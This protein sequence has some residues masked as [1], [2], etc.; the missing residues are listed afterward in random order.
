VYSKKIITTALA[1]MAF[2]TFSYGDYYDQIEK[3]DL[4]R[5]KDYK[6][7]NATIKKPDTSIYMDR[8][9]NAMKGLTQ[10]IDSYEKN[11]YGGVTKK[12]ILNN[13]K[14]NPKGSGN[15]LTNLDLDLSDFTQKNRI[16]VFMSSSV[17][18][19]IWYEYGAFIHNNKL[20]NASMLIRGCVNGCKKIKPTT[21]FMRKVIEYKP[22]QIINPSILIDPLLFKRFKMEEVPCVVFA[23]GVTITNDYEGSE[24]NEGQVKNNTYYKSCGDW[25]MMYHI[26]ELEKQSKDP[27]LKKLIKEIKEGQ[28]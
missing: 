24:G 13:L 8:V 25:S 15:N 20:H 12:D 23:K 14:N 1:L 10:R 16:Y 22:K 4:K 2:G 17:P 21:D 5:D 28:K 3:M 27:T 11:V 19:P 18:L 26:E 7:L 9:N 6:E